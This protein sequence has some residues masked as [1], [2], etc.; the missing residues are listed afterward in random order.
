MELLGRG[1]FQYYDACISLTGIDEENII[2]SMFADKIGVKKLLQ[3]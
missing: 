2:I 1:K 3:K